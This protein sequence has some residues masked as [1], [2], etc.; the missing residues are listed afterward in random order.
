MLELNSDK[1]VGKPL[2]DKLN[3]K[4]NEVWYG[5]MSN[6]D[7]VVGLF[8]RDDSP[9]SYSLSLGTLGIEGEWKMRDLWRHA[10]EGTVTTISATV[11]GH[12][13]KIVRLSK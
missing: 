8:N 6:G 11:A 13:C 5:Q 3:D 9:R 7:Y 1:F 10:D 4:D 2:S 12:G